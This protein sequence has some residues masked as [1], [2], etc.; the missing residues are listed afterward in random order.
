MLWQNSSFLAGNL[1]STLTK[2]FFSFLFLWKKL[3]SFPID[4]HTLRTQKIGFG[5]SFSRVP[6]YL[7]VARG[8]RDKAGGVST[9][10]A[11]PFS[12]RV[13][14]IPSLPAS[15]AFHLPFPQAST[16]QQGVGKKGKL[17]KMELFS[18]AATPCHSQFL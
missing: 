18:G 9:V 12:S 11:R 3:G 2:K 1:S 17:S 7:P 15:P 16:C 14:C 8:V 6:L 4:L 10:L 5:R 13:P